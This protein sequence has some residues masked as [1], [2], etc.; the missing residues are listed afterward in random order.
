MKNKIIAI[1]D[2]WAWGE[3]AWPDYLLE[4]YNHKIQSRKYNLDGQGNLS[5][6]DL[7][8][9]ESEEQKNS[10]LI[11]LRDKYYPEYDILNKGLPGH[12]SQSAVRSLRQDTQLNSGDIII[13]MFSMTCRWDVYRNSRWETVHPDSENIHNYPIRPESA[14]LGASYY[15]AH[16]EEYNWDIWTVFDILELQDI[17]TVNNCD[18]YMCNGFGEL[19]LSTVEDP[20]VQKVDQSKWLHN[21]MSHNSFL[22]KLLEL[23]N[24][25]VNNLIDAISHYSSLEKNSTYLTNCMGT[26]P[27]ILGHE[28]IADTLGTLIKNMNEK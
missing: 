19:N 11:K 1:G 23:D 17:A 14:E 24:A 15:L 9:I 20:V 12:G 16:I 8:E 6:E 25:P 4:K 28:V 13:A 3:G 10:W 21:Y 22:E 27:T 2:S 26:H 18:L 5:E 7:G